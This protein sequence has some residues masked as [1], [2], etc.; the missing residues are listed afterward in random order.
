MNKYKKVLTKSPKKYY[1]IYENDEVMSES[2][3]MERLNNISLLVKELKSE[4]VRNEN[5][6]IKVAKIR[7]ENEDL[8]LNVYKLEEVVSKAK[9]HIEELCLYYD[10]PPPQATIDK[11]DSAISNIKE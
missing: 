4:R 8:C 7:A 5:L 3:I 1:A 2:L 11:I 10:V 9:Q 6:E